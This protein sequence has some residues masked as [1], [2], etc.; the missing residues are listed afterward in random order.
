MYCFLLD[1]RQKYGCLKF[2][3]IYNTNFENVNL[4]PLHRT[5]IRYCR[6]TYDGCGEWY[7]LGNRI[8]NCETT[9]P[10]LQLSDPRVLLST[11][12]E[13]CGTTARFECPE[14]YIIS[15][16]EHSE[17][18]VNGTWSNEP[19]VCKAVSCPSPPEVD[20]GLTFLCHTFFSSFHFSLS[21]SA[22]KMI[23]S[24]VSNFN[25]NV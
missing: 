20:N 22:G 8:D 17:C 1:F 13:S 2:K 9:C 21:I 10:S 4:P 23:L 6:G 11:R 5:N 18:L 25:S 12:D 15:G 19:P 3:N 16:G 24:Y 14:C 7:C